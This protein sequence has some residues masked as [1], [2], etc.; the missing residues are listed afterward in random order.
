VCSSVKE[1]PVGIAIMKDVLECCVKVVLEEPVVLPL[2]FLF[3]GDHCIF[4][5]EECI[6]EISQRKV[7]INCDERFA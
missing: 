1:S 7:T 3:L 5:F 2:Y 4:L 6:E